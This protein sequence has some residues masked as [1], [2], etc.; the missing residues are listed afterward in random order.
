VTTPLYDEGCSEKSITIGEDDMDH[1]VDRRKEAREAATMSTPKKKESSYEW[2]IRK[3]NEYSSQLLAKHRAALKLALEEEQKTKEAEEESKTIDEV[4]RFRE[5]TRA[6]YS[7]TFPIHRIH[8]ELKR[9]AGISSRE[10]KM[11]TEAAIYLSGV[12]EGITQLVLESSVKFAR[13]DQWNTILPSHV[14]FAL[15]TD[16]PLDE[17]CKR[18]GVIIPF[19]G[20]N[21]T[22]EPELST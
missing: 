6:N 14:M 7:N 22:A 10:S 17:V 12:M 13:A 20:A 5:R 11:S 18:G 2:G 21:H 15:R 16:K 3:R 19:A 8:N 9:A 4:K 1:S